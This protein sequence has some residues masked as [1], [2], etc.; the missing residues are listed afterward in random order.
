MCIGY[1]QI[2]C[3]FTQGTRASTDFG[4]EES[5]NQS[6]ADTKGQLYSSRSTKSISSYLSLVFQ[7]LCQ[8]WNSRVF[9]IPVLYVHSSFYI[10]YSLSF[11]SF[12]KCPNIYQELGPMSLSA[13]WRPVISSFPSI[14]VT[15]YCHEKVFT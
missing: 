3:H 7:L 12:H 6:S 13:L 5:W 9:H 14:G 10:E 11:S 1:M 15:L 4:M 8:K 2:L